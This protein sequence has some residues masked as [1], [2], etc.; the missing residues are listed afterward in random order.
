[1]VQAVRRAFLHR[2][3]SLATHRRLCSRLPQ[4]RFN[5]GMHVNYHESVLRIQDRLPMFNDLP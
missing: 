5:A 1:V 4:L 2:T 3:S